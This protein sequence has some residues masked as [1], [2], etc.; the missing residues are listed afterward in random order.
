MLKCL[1]HLLLLHV[2]TQFLVSSTSYE[3]FLDEGLVFY[4]VMYC[5]FMGDCCYCIPPPGGPPYIVYPWTDF[6]MYVPLFFI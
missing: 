5:L 4:F 2:I 1:T 3:A 6:V